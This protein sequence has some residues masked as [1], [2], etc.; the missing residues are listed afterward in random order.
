VI[1]R[2]SDAT[3]NLRGRFLIKLSPK[4]LCPEGKFAGELRL[5]CVYL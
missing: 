1:N 2:A 5:F 4:N 3:F